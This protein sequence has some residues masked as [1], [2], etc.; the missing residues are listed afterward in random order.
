M[1]YARCRRLCTHS[2]PG[3]RHSSLS[4]SLS[5]PHTHS[6]TQSRC[7]RAPCICTHN[8]AYLLIHHHPRR[9]LHRH[10]HLQP[11]ADHPA[12]PAALPTLP[13]GYIR[14]PTKCQ[15]PKCAQPLNTRKITIRP[16]SASRLI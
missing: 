14:A 9:H 2:V 3:V 15:H 13:R 7:V 4:L 6:L 1:L 11:C 16:Q 8:N 12:G 5:H 10:H